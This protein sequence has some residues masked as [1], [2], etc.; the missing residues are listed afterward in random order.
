MP[1]SE[2]DAT[3]GADAWPHSRLALTPDSV[4]LPAL[5]VRVYPEP[6]LWSNISHRAETRAR[7]VSVALSRM[8]ITALSRSDFVQAVVDSPGISTDTIG[9]TQTGVVW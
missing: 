2:Y 6:G 8:P 7:C 9:K 1:V 4:R 5:A 3:L